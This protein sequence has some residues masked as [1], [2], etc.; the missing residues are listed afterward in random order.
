MF[1]YIRLIWKRGT[2]PKGAVVSLAAP[3]M[4]EGEVG[5]AASA[6]AGQMQCPEGLVECG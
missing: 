6:A 5:V 1:L 4:L 2:Q 3:A